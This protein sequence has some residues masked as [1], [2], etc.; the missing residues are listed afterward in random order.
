MHKKIDLNCDLGE[1][2]DIN[3]MDSDAAILDYVSS[4]NIACGFHAG[5]AAVMRKTV[6]LALQKGVAIGAHPGFQDLEG[7]G[8]RP[9]P[10][11]PQEAYELT[12]YQIGALHGFVQAAG[13]K[14]NHVKPHGALYNQA[15][16]NRP[17][18]D[19]IAQ[20][21]KDFDPALILY[22]L[23]GSESIRAA[24]SIGLTTAAEAF[25]DRSYQVD[26]SLTPRDQPGALLVLPEDSIA[27][28]LSIVRDG[29][30]RTLTQDDVTLAA[31]TICLHG[32]GEHAL[33][34]AEV[35]TRALREDDIL[36][37]PLRA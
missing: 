34:F 19:A 25:C 32:D 4:C 15:A 16:K 2:Q 7:F 6:E 5:N 24:D 20:A 21:V 29:T 31:E 12:L 1:R 28:V 30:V 35:L 18:A 36:I 11:T 10:V 37:S 3:Q 27:Q 26:G 8:R 9:M 23:A 17:L 14:L 22:G 13:G 33:Q